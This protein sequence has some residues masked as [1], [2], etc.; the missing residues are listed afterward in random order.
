MLL[1][2]L[3]HFFFL[4]LSF[5]SEPGRK[6]FSF[7]DT[8]R[9]YALLSPPLFSNLGPKV[10]FCIELES[11]M[12][13]IRVSL[14][15]FCCLSRLVLAHVCFSPFPRSPPPRFVCSVP[16]LFSFLVSVFLPWSWYRWLVWLGILLSPSYQN[17][18]PLF[19][20]PPP[21]AISDPSFS[22]P[23]AVGI[24]LPPGPCYP[25]IS[26]SV[27]RFSLVPPFCGSI[28][29][30]FLAKSYPNFFVETPFFFPFDC[31]FSETSFPPPKSKDFVLFFLQTLTIPRFP[32]FVPV[33][34]RRR[35]S[36]SF[37]QFLSIKTSRPFVRWILFSY[38]YPPLPGPVLFCFLF[39]R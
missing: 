31:A 38:V 15:P 18:H 17:T 34:P 8:L 27:W 22:P 1:P 14:H 24:F 16:F 32:L 3:F 33:R 2:F 37:S 19:P 7:L 5:I 28:F 23:P 39:F 29:G 26:V 21:S 35:G 4:L 10:F 36:R 9:T 13:E 12:Q 25:L 6:R 30:M 11:H 20:T